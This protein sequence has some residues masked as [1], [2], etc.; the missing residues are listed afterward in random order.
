[1]YFQDMTPYTYT[2]VRLADD[3]P[4]M[5]NFGW[6]DSAHEYTSG[7]VPPWLVT[8]AL[9]LAAKYINGTRGYHRCPFC[10]DRDQVV[11]LLGS[12]KVFLGSAEIRVRAAS[13]TYI[14]PSLLPH[15]V[16][17]HGYR[18]PAEILDALDCQRQ[19][20]DDY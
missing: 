3:A 12:E 2:A 16:S 17:V 15:Y 4:L 5:L 8:C 18:P 11:M 1:M 20:G 19:R 10:R 6:L 14:A 7:Q 13:A 9:G